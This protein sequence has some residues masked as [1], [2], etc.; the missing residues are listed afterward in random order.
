MP[1]R[2]TS[3]R[4][5]IG[6]GSNL[7]T[8][9]ANCLEAVRRISRKDGIQV[10]ALSS[11]YETEPQDIV[12]ENIFINAVLEMRT[13]LEPGP[14]L[15]FL[16]EIEGQMGRDRNM[17]PDRTL[18]LDI[19]FMEGVTV[20]GSREEGSLVLPHPRAGKRAFVLVPWAELAPDLFV[21]SWGKTVGQMLDGLESLH[22]VL[23]K[24]PWQRFEE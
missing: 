11:A 8:R 6:L 13:V 14:L 21:E 16:L 18:D 7:G 12:S 4:T 20:S 17:G 23:R 22:P 24:L 15:N 3:R 1:E 19:L 2:G 10:V 5:F 9:R